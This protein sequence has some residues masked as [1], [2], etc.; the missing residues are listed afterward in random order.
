MDGFS[1]LLKES[2]YAEVEGSTPPARSI[3]ANEGHSSYLCT[4][5]QGKFHLPGLGKGCTLSAEVTFIEQGVLHIFRLRQFYL[6]HLKRKMFN[7]IVVLYSAVMIV[8]FAIAATLVYQYQTQ[9]ILREQTDANLKSAHVL[10]IYLSLQ[11]EGIQNI[12]QQIYGDASLSDDLIY[13]LN[14]EYESYLKYRLD[15]Y[16][17]TGEQRLRSFNP[18][19][20]NYLEQE[21]SAKSVS[22]YSYPNNFYMHISRNNQQ[23]NNDSGSKNKWETW[24]A[25]R[26]QDSWDTMP[27]NEA[28]PSSDGSS[29]RSYSYSREIKDPW[30]LERVGMMNVEFDARQISSWLESR[31]SVKGRILVLNAQQTVIYDSEDVLYGQTYPYQLEHEKAG[32][33]V[34]LDE[35]SKV[36]I[37]NVG[38]AG[39]SVV[40]IVS[41]SMIKESTKSLRTG[42]ILVTL[43]FM[44]TSFAITFTIVRKFSKKVQRIIRSMNR[45]GEGDLSTRIQMSGEDELQQISRRFN[46]M[47]DRL[48]Q[49]IDKMYT[50]EIKQK[51]AELVA[52]QSQINPHFLYNTLESIR[53]KAYFVGAKEVG[54]MIY[55]LSV[56]FKSMV[57]KSTIVTIEEEIDMCSVYLD[58]FR[59]RYEGRLET[60]IEMDPEIQNYSIIKLLV[61]PI[62]ENYIVHGFRPLEDNNKISVRAQG[63]GDRI[64]I[65]VSDNGT[66]IPEEKLTQIRQ[67]L[68]K[69]LQPPD[70]GY[71][72]IGLMN[73]HERIVMN[74]G[75]DYGVFINSTEGVGTEVR[76]EIPM[77]RKGETT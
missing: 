62:V 64:V 72:S 60:E 22:I 8:L 1:L 76:M 26:E 74:Y 66:G 56:M 11:Y 32:D 37:L 2:P 50:S 34:Q 42:M 46:D 65:I 57:K 45:I 47:G 5:E 20:K 59:I 75:N 17:K 15:L 40:G 55:S 67:T 30:T 21:S 41:Q 43:V 35:P 9:R 27:Q 49:Y 68:D 4:C 54:Q 44:V 52:L 28:S 12:F 29:P 13:F 51:N 33:W 58:L 71:R 19:L 73:V 25:R 14:H 38:N 39:L 23:L 7:K 16:A 18:L 31:A 69:I 70:K 61:Q 77:L 53:M 10:N 48:E 36:N 3:Q 24:F 63:V 6:N